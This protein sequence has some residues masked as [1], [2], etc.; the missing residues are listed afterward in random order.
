MLIFGIFVLIISYFI[1]I[2]YFI[3]PLS[4]NPHAFTPIFWFSY[5]FILRSKQLA[6]TEN[7]WREGAMLGLLGHVLLFAIIIIFWNVGQGFVMDL[8]LYVYSPITYLAALFFQ[9][10]YFYNPYGEIHDITKLTIAVKFILLNIYTYILIGAIIGGLFK[11]QKL[12]VLH[13]EI[14][15]DEIWLEWHHKKK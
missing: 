4:Y 2:G 10:E 5:L 6:N 14:L 15:N 1:A 12:A 13:N 11:K 9:Y 3:A 8:L 7:Y